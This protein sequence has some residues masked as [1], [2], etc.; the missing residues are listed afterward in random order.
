MP[1]WRTFFFF[2]LE[3]FYVK[4]K[5]LLHSL[6]TIFKTKSI[7]KVDLNKL[8][9]FHFVNV[10]CE[11]LCDESCAF[12]LIHYAER[13]SPLSAING[14][15]H[16]EKCFQAINCGGKKNILKWF[17]HKIYINCLWQSGARKALWHWFIIFQVIQKRK[18]GDVTVNLKWPCCW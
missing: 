3:Q 2:S 7:P 5:D 8:K 16:L 9:G 4:V 17:I 18:K 1:K 6:L 12:Q 10:Y 14:C 11:L 15:L 13:S